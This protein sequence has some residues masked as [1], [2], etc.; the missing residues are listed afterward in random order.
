[1]SRAQYSANGF[2]IEN[3]NARR[4]AI[5]TICSNNYVSMARILIASARRFHPE[6]TIYLGLADVALPDK[7]FYP[8][9][10]VVLPVEK[11]DI[12]NI[13]SFLFRYD[14][15]ELN[16]AIKPFVF[17]HLLRLGHDTVLYFDPDI[18]L[19]S[20]L[21]QVLTP[22]Q[23]GASF[24]LTPHLC[25]PAEGDAFPDDIGIMQAGIYNL[26][27]LGVQACAEAESILAWWARRLEY[28]CISDQSAGIFVDQKFM[29]L[30]PGFAKHAAILRDPEVNIAYW[31]LSQRTLSFDGD[32]WTVDGRPLGFYHFSGFDPAKM[33][34][35]AKYTLAFRDDAITPSLFRLMDQYAAQLRANNHGRVPAGLYAYGRFASG[36]RI[37]RIVRKMF[38][39]RHSTWFGDPFETYETYLQAPMPGQPDGSSSAVVTNLMG[40]LHEQEPWLRQN[41]D[42]S[43]RSGVQGLEEWFVGHGESLVEHCGL[44]EP[45]AERMGRRLGTSPRT[46]PAQRT[47]DEADINVVGYL[48]AALGLGEAGRLT[49]RALNHSGLRARGL[50]TSHN[51]A[52]KRIDASCDHL[53][54]PEANGR[55]QLFSINCDQLPQVMDHLRPVLRPDAYRIMAPFWELS[56]LPDAWLAATDE[57]DEIW[58]PTRFI[59]AMLAKKV[60]KPVLRM[61]LMLDFETPA[62]IDRSQFRLPHRS[63]LFFFAFD[64]F[65]FIE[66]KNPMAVVAAFKR[67][68][69]AAGHDRPVQLVLKTLNADVA[70][71]SGQALRQTI[72]DDPDIILIEKTLTREQTL[73]LIAAC[74]AVVT[75]HRSEGLGLLVAEAMVLGKPVI[76]TDYSAT[77]ELVTPKTGWPVDYRLTAVQAGMYPFH[78]GQVWAD[79]DIDHAAWQMRRVVDDQPEARRRAAAAH[80]LISRDYGIDAVARRQLARLTSLERNDGRVAIEAE[81]Q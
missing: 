42:R 76:A 40:Y 11:L 73:A 43:Q 34:R 24:V 59:Q 58:A 78:E 23:D 37:P 80:A 48:R 47:P 17:Q 74:D 33:D 38:R 68:F 64:Y 72:K 75:L 3:R 25:E 16:T 60:R 51:S 53:L 65:S 32:G 5:F 31:N 9:D 71:E 21:N 39:E 70:H 41:F 1:M 26:G 7:G 2:S 22:L 61:P 54:E 36:T 69:R 20:R 81:L 46:P 52:S 6:A 14:I 63:F 55:F 35:L 8:E 77:T 62:Q 49:L 66:R 45:V 28:Q 27:F 57:V 67:A 15:M 44:T 18:Q 13:R 56:N 79:A 10:C 12:P 50:E 4:L 30:V 29:D 19:F